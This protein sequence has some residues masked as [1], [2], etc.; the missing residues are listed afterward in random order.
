[1]DLFDLS[2]FLASTYKALA[3]KA[4]ADSHQQMSR[5]PSVALG[6]YSM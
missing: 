5:R 3:S 4:L 1:M 2:V 6:H